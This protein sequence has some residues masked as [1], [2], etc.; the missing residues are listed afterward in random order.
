MRVSPLRTTRAR[1][2]SLARPVP[3][4]SARAPA[5]PVHDDAFDGRRNARELVALIAV[6]RPRLPPR[7]VC[8]AGRLDIFWGWR[9][10]RGFGWRRRRK[11]TQGYEYHS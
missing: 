3:A 6:G 10:R 11:R 8:E 4:P 5:H 9:W 7:R 2:R 1:S